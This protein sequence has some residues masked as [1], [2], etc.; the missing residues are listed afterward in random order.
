MH[1]NGWRL[2]VMALALAASPAPCAVATSSDPPQ[3]S[4]QD[5]SGIGRESGV[6]RRDPSDVIR[7]KDTWYVWYTRVAAAAP[8]YPSGYHGT[9]WYATSTDGGHHWMEQG[10]ALGT[11]PAGAFDA[12]AVFTPNILPYQG[13]YYLYY[14]AVAEGFTNT[15]YAESGKTRIGVAVA[16]SPDGPWTRP[17]ANPL[18]E[19]SP[20]HERFDSYRVDDACL[21]VHDGAVR[22]YYKG[23]QWRH[24]PRQTKMGVAEAA[25]PLGPFTRLHDGR[26]V[27]DS[28]HEVL[29]WPYRGGIRSLASNTGPRG[30]SLFH[31][32]DGISFHVVQGRLTGL[33]NAPGAYREDLS[34]SPEF[35]DGIRWGISMVHGPDPY[36]VRFEMTSP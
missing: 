24:T 5:I 18:L 33:P 25:G 31:A 14:T 8:L 29:V 15:G 10:R 35:D 28:G 26:H 19:P 30:Q 21:V 22:L 7:V 2:V 34:G 23:R 27:Q 17:R 36:L 9:I 12:H 32:P 16:D 6:C 3:F 11:G 20:N 13:A 1:R 4:V